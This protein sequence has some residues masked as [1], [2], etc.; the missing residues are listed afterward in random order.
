MYT[1]ITQGYRYTS[2]PDCRPGAKN[3]AC[4]SLAVKKKEK[5]KRRKE[6]DCFQTISSGVGFHMYNE[7]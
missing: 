3:Q 5:K 6:T 2:N 1:V 4:P 7:S